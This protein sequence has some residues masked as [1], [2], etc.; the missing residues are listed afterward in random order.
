MADRVIPRAALIATIAEGS[1]SRMS[2]GRSALEMQVAPQPALEALADG[3]CILDRDWRITY[4]N[5]AAERLVRQRRERLLGRVLWSEFPLLR[6][7]ATW[8][9]LRVARADGKAQDYTEAMPRRRGR[10]FAAVHAA[11]LADGSLLVQFRDATEEVTRRAEHTN[12]LESIRDGFVAVDAGWRVVYINHVAEAILRFSRE[13]ALGRSLWPL[14]PHG[15]SSIAASLRATAEDGEPRHLR[16]VRPEGRIFRGRIFDLWIY[17]LH[18]GGLSLMFEDVTQRVRRE[19]ELAQLVV[20]AN[21]ANEAKGRFFAAISHELR[22]PLNAIVG[23]T[24]LLN[25]DTYGQLPESARRAAVRAGVCAEHLSR[26]VDDVLLLTTA[27]I[28]KLPVV[29]EEVV[30]RDFLPPVLEPHRHQAEAKGLHFSWIVGAGAEVL[31]TD[32]QR[33]RQLMASLV[34]NAVKFTAAGEVRIEV[35]RSGADDGTTP[36]ICFRVVDTG[37]GIAPDDQDRIFGPFEQIGDPSRS[38]SMSMGS[39]L[40]LTVASRLARLLDGTLRLEA[41]SEAG[42][43]FCLRLPLRTP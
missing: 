19:E 33:L 40:G 2:R 5:A 20:R 12:L 7:S 6:G 27:E 21:E 30:V 10:G 14:L 17:P 3:V 1:E 31:E 9:A 15:P 32:P 38:Q 4:L 13:H 22:T 11:P 29:P 35:E 34:S 41:S 23:Y 18:G 16:E 42:S 25:T 36:G 26:L 8:D 28:G 39:G 43:R 37:R 24:H